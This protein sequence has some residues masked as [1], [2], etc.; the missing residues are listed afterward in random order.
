MGKMV[1]FPI[2]AE[3]ETM[4]KKEPVQEEYSKRGSQQDLPE[5][6]QKGFGERW[7]KM[8]KNNVQEMKEGERRYFKITVFC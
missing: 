3:I 2:K 4:E 1:N 8:L 6:K 5:M 7:D